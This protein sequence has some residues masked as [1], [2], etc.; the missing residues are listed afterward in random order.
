MTETDTGRQ[1]PGMRAVVSALTLLAL[2]QLAA[3]AAPDEPGAASAADEIIQGE[4]IEI[5]RAPWQV[6][7]HDGYPLGPDNGRF[8]HASK[9]GGVVLAPEWILTAHH[10]LGSRG[11]PRG[12]WILAGAD[13]HAAGFAISGQTLEGVQAVETD[14][15]FPYA[16]MWRPA[17]APRPFNDGY[18]D[19]DRARDLELVHLMTP[20]DLGGDRVKA[21]ELADDDDVAAGR[22]AAGVKA[23]VSGFG[24]AKYASTLPRLRGGYTSLLG[25]A[26]AERRYRKDPDSADFELLPNE[27]AALPASDATKTRACFG[28]SGGPLVVPGPAGKEILA[29]IVSWGGGAYCAEPEL[30]DIYMRV[31]F[32]APWVR[33]TMAGYDAA[34]RR[35]AE[36]TVPEG[37]AASREGLAKDTACRVVESKLLER[38]WQDVGPQELDL[39]AFACAGSF[40][41][42]RGSAGAIGDG[43]VRSV[44][45]AT[46]GPG[47][48]TFELDACLVHPV[49]DAADWWVAT[50]VE[51]GAACQ[52]PNRP[53]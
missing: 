36:V 2:A 19:F 42:T 7:I 50:F 52:R 25:D 14:V 49:D 28:D 4:Y 8:D 22:T 24:S 16:R 38:G 37:A 18:D 48:R 15:S 29:G 43:R 11:T 6:S 39:A 33:E 1:S 13:D 27:L 30:A 3:C 46:R 23:F 9:C 44:R 41:P 53:Y 10:C 21:I 40:E 31:S 45:F 17:H 51:P 5:G 32:F 47:A 34:Q 35:L 26:E 12:L 20:L